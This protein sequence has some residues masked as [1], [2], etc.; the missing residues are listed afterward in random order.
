MEL[1]NFGRPRE[2]QKAVN[3][4]CK[5]KKLQLGGTLE[6][7]LWPAKNFFEGAGKLEK[8]LKLQKVSE[9]DCQVI[10]KI[11]NKLQKYVKILTSMAQ[12]FISSPSF[13]SYI[14]NKHLWRHSIS[15]IITNSSK[16]NNACSLKDC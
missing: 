13:I 10:D 15:R 11:L 4:W 6:K 5:L 2:L 8:T 3:F 1:V 7:K 14:I 9:L 16:F 12:P